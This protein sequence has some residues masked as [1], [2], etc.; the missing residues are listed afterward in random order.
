MGTR[1]LNVL[2]GAA[3]LACSLLALPAP[4]FGL[5]PP[6]AQEEYLPI[7]QLPPTE[8]LP[9]GV[10]VVIAYGFIWVA[11][12][13]YVWSLWRRLG[14]VEAEMQALQRRSGSQTR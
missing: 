13:L 6:P 10:F 9:G 2:A 3:A 1:L 11:V 4:L 12:M 14:K 8:Q 7:D 5:Q